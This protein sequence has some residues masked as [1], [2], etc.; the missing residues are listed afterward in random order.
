MLHFVVACG[1][2]DELFGQFALHEVIVGLGAAFGFPCFVLH[3]WSLGPLV[4]CGSFWGL[5]SGILGCLLFLI[6]FNGDFSAGV[7]LYAVGCLPVWALGIL[8]AVVAHDVFFCL[9]FFLKIVVLL[10]L[11]L[12]FLLGFGIGF[13][14]S[15]LFRLFSYFVCFLCGGLSLVPGFALCLG[16]L[17]SLSLVFAYLGARSCLLGGLQPYEDILPA[18]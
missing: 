4:L 13:F 2:G 5:S 12:L 15:C 16:F 3:G 14:T 11:L 17:I 6:N 9:L 18:F 7:L 8:C 10:L 1:A